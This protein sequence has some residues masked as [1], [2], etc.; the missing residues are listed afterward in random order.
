MKTIAPRTYQV[1]LGEFPLT[2]TVT[3]RNTGGHAATTVIIGHVRE[4]K[5]GVEISETD[6]VETEQGGVLTYEIGTPSAPPS[7]VVQTLLAFFAKKE[8]DAA[9]FEVA[10]TT[11]GGD[12]ARTFLRR[13]AINPNVG[14]LKFTVGAS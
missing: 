1:T 7:D 9:R 14:T 12:T 10:I 11:A 13:P 6:V 2:V 8:P 4:V 5:D 3:P